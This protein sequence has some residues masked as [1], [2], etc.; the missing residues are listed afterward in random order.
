[1]LRPR[2]ICVGLRR[3]DGDPNTA[4]SRYFALIAHEHSRTCSGCVGLHLAHDSNRAP[5]QVIHTV[6]L[7]EEDGAH[8]RRS[9]WASSNWRIHGSRISIAHSET[10][11][12][13][14]SEDLAGH[15][16]SSGIYLAPSP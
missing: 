8:P 14:P 11:L 2:N 15:P 6:S 10:L 3:G 9:L 4:T 12:R 1:M 13:H 7:S 5:A 16:V